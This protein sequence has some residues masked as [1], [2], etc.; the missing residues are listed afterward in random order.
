M[1]YNKIGFLAGVGGNPTGIGEYVRR[2]DAAGK[3][4]VVLSNDGTTGLSDL[5]ALGEWRAPHVAGFRVVRDGSEA[6]SVPEYHLSPHEA[7]VWHWTKI[8]PHIPREGVANR[9][10]VWIFPIN[11]VDKTKADWLGRFSVELAQIANGEGFKVAMFAW[12]SGE[13]EPDAWHTAGMLEYLRY[14]AAHPD[15]AAINLHEYSYEVDDIRALHPYRIGRFQFL[16]DV[17]DMYGIARPKIIVGEWGWTL[18]NVP[19]VESAMQDIAWAAQLYAPHAN[20]LGAG[21]WYLGPYNKTNIADKAQRLIAPVTEYSLTAVFDPPIPPPP[22]DPEEPPVEKHTVIVVKLPQNMT[23]EEWVQAAAAAYPFRH[24][25]TASH[26]DMLTVLL[27]GNSRSTVKFTHPD[28]DA[29]SVALVEAMGYRWEPFPPVTLPPAGPWLDVDPISQRDPRWAGEVLGEWTGH[30]KT[31]GNWG[32][33]LVAYTAMGRYWGLTQRDPGAENDHYVAMGAFRAQFIQPGALRTAYPDDVQYLGYLPRDDARMRP[34]IREWIDNGWPVPARVDFI[35]ATA[36][37]DQHWVLIVGY[38]GDSEFYMMDP[39]H[40]DIVTVNERYA[41]AGSD[42]LEAI[43]YRPMDAAPP[44]PQLPPAQAIDLV[45]Y[46][47]PAERRIYEVRHPDG[48]QER[49]QTQVDGQTAYIVKGENQG[50]W[51]R[52]SW[53]EQ[54]IYLERDTSPGPDGV[55]YDVARVD[56]RR[57]PWCRR[58]MVLGEQFTDGGHV[59]TFKSKATCLPIDDPRSGN[60][61]NATKLLKH[62]DRLALP[63]GLAFDDVII[64]RGNTEE[65]GFAR[66]IGRVYWSAPWGESAVSELHAPGARPDIVRESGCFGG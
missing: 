8:R 59:V 12:A 54:Y 44:E 31:I 66:G 41:I 33:L 40:G 23:F 11:E 34:R 43:Y 61:A 47:F 51:E 36:Q 27:G 58:R 25:V 26:D 28:R 5:F 6:W 21:I 17:C 48:S 2:L 10:R 4:A 62:N 29:D 18:D 52:W 64:I 35:P 20:I 32:C 9:H 16:H 39:W 13:P 3:P 45:P 63:T 1:S 50:F 7:A 53:D 30:S 57:T 24:T 60:A 19:P 15:Q 56:G 22:V 49:I 38:E 55:Y 65:H 37:W 46:M 14:C 42:I